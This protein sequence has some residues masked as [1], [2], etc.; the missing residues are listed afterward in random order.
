MAGI[1]LI[2]LLV[3][4]IAGMVANAQVDISLWSSDDRA[5]V[6]FA[7]MVLSIMLISGMGAKK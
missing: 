1:F 3:C 4:V 5:I 6:V 7:A 2:T